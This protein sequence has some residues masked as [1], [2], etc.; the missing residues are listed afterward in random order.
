MTNEEPIYI[1]RKGLHE[2]RRG[3]L[4]RLA[5]IENLLKIPKSII[6]KTLRKPWKEFLEEYNGVML[7]DYPD[8]DWDDLEVDKI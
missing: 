6:P 7:N 1:D 5:V 3:L 2:E 4:H 8:N